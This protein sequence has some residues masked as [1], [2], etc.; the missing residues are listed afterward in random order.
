MT[1]SSEVND[2][3]LLQLIHDDPQQG[4]SLLL[5]QY[6]GRIRGYLRQR[7]P[8]LHESDLQSAVTDAMLGLA[9]SFD[10][11]RGALPAWFLLLAHQAAVAMLRAGSLAAATAAEEQH[12]EEIE[13]GVE[14]LAELE[15]R[16]RLLEVYQVIE[17]LPPLE[18]AVLEADLAEGHT[19]A[20]QPLA[21]RLGTTVASVYAARKRARA[22]LAG[23][24]SW[25][26][27]SLQSGNAD[28]GSS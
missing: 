11:T 17:S 24:C 28:H 23:R 2:L 13:G 20:S 4:F 26:R 9:K 12:L 27:D 5:D 1:W 8:S 22:K 21:E 10:P 7:F 16:E 6:G 3:E 15:T 19:T 25:V 14:P 18:R